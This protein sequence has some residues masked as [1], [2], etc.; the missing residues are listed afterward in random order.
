[1]CVCFFFFML[2]WLLFFEKAHFIFFLNFKFHSKKLKMAALSQDI[3]L[4]IDKHK[5]VIEHMRLNMGVTINAAV[6]AE[7][8]KDR[9]R[10]KLILIF[11]FVI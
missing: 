3:T 1:V 11:L 4:I 10:V 7:R 6:A 2:D 8:H 5:E 9:K